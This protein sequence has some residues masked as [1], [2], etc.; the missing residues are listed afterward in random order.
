MHSHPRLRSMAGAALLLC[1]LCTYRAASAATF[2]TPLAGPTNTNPYQFYVCTNSSFGEGPAI[3]YSVNG[4]PFV[5]SPASFVTNNT[6]TCSGSIFQATVPRQMDATVQYQFFNLSTF[7]D[8]SSSRS[9]FTGFQSFT[10]DAKGNPTPAAGP[11]PAP[12]DILISEF[13]FRGAAGAQDEFIELYNNTDNEITVNDP[14][15]GLA[16]VS[17]DAPATPK[18]LIPNG[19]AIPAR[20]HFLAVNNT[21]TTG[22]SLSAY[23]AGS[24][25]TATGDVTYTGDIPDNGGIA[26]FNT[27]NPN[28]FDL[29]HRIDA[30]GHSVVT[31]TR[32]REGTGIGGV[33][34][35]NG[36][37]S[38]IRKLNTGVPQDTNDNDN[39][40]LFIATLAGG[41]IFGL[42]SDIAVLGGP[43]P[44]NLSSPIQR[45]AQIKSAQIEN[46][47]GTGSATPVGGCQNRVRLLT[48]DPNNPAA[49][50]N[51]QLL[52]RRKF[53]NTTGG[54]VTRLRF[55]IVDMTTSF[56]NPGQADLRALSSEDITVVRSDGGGTVDVKGLTLEQPPAQPDGGGI[57]SSLATG[58][59]TTATPLASGASIAVEFRLGVV[60]SGAFRFFVNVEAVS[61]PSS[62]ILKTVTKKPAASARKSL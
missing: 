14:F 10:T 11:A 47:T 23:P 12:G 33:P 52:I 24:T 27:A 16:V 51:G 62:V 2:I 57:N 1:A 58:M 40:F 48:P 35:A 44:E 30:V 22:Y 20:G 26:L 61:Q 21:P 45:N 43:G 18:F 3:E 59:I 15:G 42:N 38:H 29:A 34:E 25:T 5:C 37:Y 53:T 55:R 49:S 50:S 46:C 17:A 41:G 36:E 13:R 54:P 8:C 4:G 39:D 9:L 56:P 6:P 60:Q 32:F 31:D 28:S 19:T 7:G